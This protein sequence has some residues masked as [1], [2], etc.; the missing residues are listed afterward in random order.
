MSR[1]AVKDLMM[2]DTEP[3]V[4]KVCIIVLATPTIIGSA[5]EVRVV[6]LSKDEDRQ[7]IRTIVDKGVATLKKRQSSKFHAEID[8]AVEQVWKVFLND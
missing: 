3:L 6:D 5:M 4:V 1:Q 7:E 2:T 8:E